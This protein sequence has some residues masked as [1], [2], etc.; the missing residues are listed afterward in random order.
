MPP[1]FACSR[2]D[3]TL[4]TLSIRRCSCTSRPWPASTP[5]SFL[6]RRP[7]LPHRDR[8]TV[9]GMKLGAESAIA[10]RLSADRAADPCAS[11]SR[12]NDSPGVLRR[13]SAGQKPR[14]HGF[15]SNT[16]ALFAHLSTIS[17]RPSSNFCRSFTDSPGR[18]LHAPQS[19]HRCRNALRPS[20]RFNGQSYDTAAPKS[21]GISGQRFAGSE[22]QLRASRWTAQAV[23][24]R[25][26]QLA[27]RT[28]H[29]PIH[30]LRD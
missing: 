13:F 1:V 7:R 10:R 28:N 8:G 19:S 9:S 24:R 30:C 29:S 2:V 21:S 12:W 14:D 15:K 26:R 16:K 23:A 4:V 27:G 11:P 20:P 3:V 25:R 22:A 6:S 18:P 17:R 5:F